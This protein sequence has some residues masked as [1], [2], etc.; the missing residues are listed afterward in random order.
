MLERDRDTYTRTSEQLEIYL[1]LCAIDK[2]TVLYRLVCV[3]CVVAIFGMSL[4]ALFVVVVAAA[5]LYCWKKIKKRNSGANR[6]YLG[7]LKM[8]SWWLNHSRHLQSK[9]AVD[10]ALP[11]PSVHGRILGI[12]FGSFDRH[13]R[14]LDDTNSVNAREQVC[15]QFVSRVVMLDVGW[16]YTETGHESVSE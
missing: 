10:L 4:C 15:V 6:K 1:D 11:L 5:N 12:C 13:M 2:Y 16:N 9:I 8:E 7:K 3:L 14:K